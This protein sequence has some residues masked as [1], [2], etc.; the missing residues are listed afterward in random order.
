MTY[1]TSDGG[2]GTAATGDGTDYTS[3]HGRPDL[4]QRGDEPVD[5]RADEGRHA[6]GRAG[7]VHGSPV[8]PDR[9]SDVG[10]AGFGDRDHH[11]RRDAAHAVCRCRLHGSRA[12]RLGD[13]DRSARR[14]DDR[15]QHGELRA[16]RCDGDRRWRRLHRYHRNAD[17]RRWRGEPHH[18]G[19]DHERHHQRDRGDVHGN[20]VEPDRRCRARNAHGGNGDDHRQRP[21][22]DRAVQ[23]GQLRGGRGPH[24]HDHSDP[25]GH[26]GSGDGR[27]R[28][29]GRAGDEP[30][31]LHRHLGHA[32]VPGRR[33]DEDVHGGDG[34]ATPRPRAASR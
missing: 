8:E 31:R 7:D 25:D 24:R 14:P 17:L 29:R 18:R 33:D 3:R 5:L 26:G 20:P 32:H 12:G 11:G 21:R 10:R 9:R 16:G 2:S 19:P 34:R 15:P 27:L 28:H 1:T 6:A 30:G 22:R 23:P 13:V 4:C